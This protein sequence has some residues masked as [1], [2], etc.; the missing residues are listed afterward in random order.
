[1]RIAIVAGTDVG[2]VRRNNEDNFI[3]CSDLSASEWTIPQIGSESDLGKFGALLFVADG[4]GGANA[5][6]V[7]SAIAVES[8]HEAFHKQSL[9]DVILSEDAI[10]NFLKDT[11][12]EADLKV[13][14]HAQE[15]K[16][17][18]GMGTT[19][20]IAWV[21]ND[22]AYICWCGDSRCYV[23][24]HHIGLTQLTKDH[25]YVQELVDKGELS[26]ENALDHPYSNIIT[27]CLGDTSKRVKPDICIYTLKEKDTLLLCTDGLCGVCHD[28]QILDVMDSCQD[29]LA[30]TKNQLIQE[31]LTNGGYDNVTVVL[32]QV[33]MDVADGD[34][35]IKSSLDMTVKSNVSPKRHAVFWIILLIMIIAL[36]GFSLYLYLEQTEEFDLIINKFLSY[37]ENVKNF[38]VTCFG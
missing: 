25:S 22:K 37:Y 14:H 5:G 24:N 11:L 12:R 6:E 1:M 27:Q 29:D 19:A 13:L 18:Q 34:K 31:A 4:M 36:V 16:S 26:P 21:L 30:D 35:L 32:C 17:T 2:L 33:Q 15:D 23:F 3:I 7:A 20:V 9:A 28:E 8:I 38:V 10:V